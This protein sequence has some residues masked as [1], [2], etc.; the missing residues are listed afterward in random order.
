LDK[1]ERMER[2]YRA[3]EQVAAG[4]APGLPMIEGLAALEDLRDRVLNELRADLPGVVRAGDKDL[5]WRIRQ[6]L[7]QL[8]G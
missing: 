2:L 4:A 7:R 1:L 6:F 3:A 8:E 5:E